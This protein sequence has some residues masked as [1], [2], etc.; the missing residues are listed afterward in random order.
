[1]PKN[2]FGPCLKNTEKRRKIYH[3][4]ED[5]RR[6]TILAPSYKAAREMCGLPSRKQKQNKLKFN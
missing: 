2:S 1:M 6:V 4:D 3:F 5:G